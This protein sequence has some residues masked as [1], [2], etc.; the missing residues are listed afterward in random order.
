TGRIKDLI[1]RG[2]QNIAPA[3]IER[4]LVRAG[5]TEAAVVGEPH[6]ALGEV[7]IAYVVGG[8]VDELWAACRAELPAYKVPDRIHVIGELPRNAI[9]K[10][11]RRK[12][13]V[14]LLDLVLAEVGVDAGDADRTFTDLG[15]TSA[16][17]V[18]LTVRLGAATGRH[19]PPTAIFDHTTP[20]A[21]AAH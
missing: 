11:A 19:V 3:E 14:P 10:V 1:I 7:P 21:L 20:R 2:G 4:V 5:A 15:V 8:N 6:T 16:T 9:G 17:A 13:A 12:L 18:E